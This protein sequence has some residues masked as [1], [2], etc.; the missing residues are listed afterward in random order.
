MKAKR[1]AIKV[2]K[3]LPLVSGHFELK[4][5]REVT[6]HVEELHETIQKLEARNDEWA[7]EVRQLRG[8][9][10]TMEILW[11][12]A[13]D[14][15][16]AADVRGKM[17]IKPAKPHKGPYVFNWVVPP[18]GPVSGGHMVIFRFINFLE[19]QGHTC[20]V[21]FYDPM[22]QS[23]FDTTKQNLKK[24]HVIKADLYYNAECM[25]DADAHIATQWTTA[26]PVFNFQGVGKKFYLIQDY[27]TIFEPS[28]TYSNLADMTY[29]MGLHGISTTPGTSVVLERDYDIRLDT[30]ELAVNQDEYY[31]TNNGK[32]KKVLFYAR[33]VTPRRGFELGI[34]TLELF[35]A[36]HPEYE[37][38][39]V[40]WDVSAYNIPFPYTNRGTISIEE[41]RQAYNESVA[42]LALSFTS[43]SLL[44]VEMMATGCQPVVNATIYTKMVEYTDGLMYTDGTPRALADALGKAATNPNAQEHAKELAEFSKKFTWTKTE[45][46]L[47]QIFDRELGL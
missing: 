11:P 35:H 32:R 17:H 14:D 18:V 9:P 31:L 10:Q 12:V 25:Q 3:K 37:I 28:G 4:R 13:K 16:I 21:Y 44:P 43:I 23:D 40:G 27:E 19:S 46:K 7:A 39:L 29:K 1:V 38:V 15:I 47:M 22:N 30:V 5:L 2:A 42:A 24:H 41:L 33:P 26:Y 45:R 20:R 36:E 8:A 6:T 34:L